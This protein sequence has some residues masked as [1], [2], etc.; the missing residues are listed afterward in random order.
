MK[1]LQEAKDKIARDH[2]FVNWKAS[3]WDGSKYTDEAAE[4]LISEFIDEIKTLKESIK[5]GSMIGAQV[6]YYENKLDSRQRTIDSQFQQIS[7]LESELLKARKL[8]DNVQI[9]HFRNDT[10]GFNCA[11]DE[12]FEYRKNVAPV[13]Q[14]KNLIDKMQD[15]DPEINKMVQENSGELIG[16]Q[17]KKTEGIVKLCSGTCFDLDECCK[18]GCQKP[19][20]NNEPEGES[21][22]YYPCVGEGICDKDRNKDL[23]CNHCGGVQAF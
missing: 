22:E 14:T 1:T 5:V 4:L 15:I 18:Y 10:T 19:K 17:T 12:I 9:T 21:E 23:I 6:E 16:E 2:G 3:H 20:V 11:M 8:L 13:E 7:E